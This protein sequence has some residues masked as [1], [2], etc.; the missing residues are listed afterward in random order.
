MKP[1]LH[2][3]SSAKTYGGIPDD[4]QKIHDFIDSS[5]AGHASMRHRAMFHNSMGPYIA[6][7]IFGVIIINSD[8]KEVSVR[9]IC[10]QHIIEDLGNIPSIDKWLSRLPLEEWMG[11]PFKSK[12]KIRLVD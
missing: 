10:E 7:Q 8:G 3:K 12:K 1:Y 9:D 4:Y 6:E 2:A 11:R 5:K